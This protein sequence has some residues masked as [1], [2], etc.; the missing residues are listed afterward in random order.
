MKKS[1]IESPAHTV[2]HLLVVSPRRWV[3]QG[4]ISAAK[5]QLHDL[6]LCLIALSPNKC[7][8]RVHTKGVVNKAG[9]K[10]QKGLHCINQSHLITYVTHL[11]MLCL[12]AW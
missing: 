3:I 12:R 11:P 2:Y 10:F 5:V 8:S 7:Q 4:L 9:R 6:N 1:G